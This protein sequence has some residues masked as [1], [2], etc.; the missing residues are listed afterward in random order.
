M[1]TLARFDVLSQKLLLIPLSILNIRIEF[2]LLLL[3]AHKKV[4]VTSVLEI[5]N[6]LKRIHKGKTK[7]VDMYVHIYLFY[8]FNLNITFGGSFSK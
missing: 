6:I 5:E 7:Q 2:S 4:K 8:C 3:F 1:Q